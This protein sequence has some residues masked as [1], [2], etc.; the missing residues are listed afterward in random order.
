[1]SVNTFKSP[2]EPVVKQSKGRVAQ[3][4]LG[5]GENQFTRAS[6]VNPIIE[7]VNAKAAVNASTTTAGNT[8]TINT[9]AGYFTTGTLTTAPTSGTG[10]PV[11][12]LTLTNSNIAATSIVFAVITAYG[13]TTGQPAI[14][15]VVP[16]AGSASIVIANV[17]TAVLNG[18]IQVKFIVF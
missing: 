17:G 11:T 6:D 18:T 1:M 8:P 9:I 13:G 3:L 7:F 10:S 12:A 2:L 15:R 5:V 14:S 4:D 16:A